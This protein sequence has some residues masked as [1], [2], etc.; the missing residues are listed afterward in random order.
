MKRD[1]KDVHIYFP[2]KVL[3]QLKRLAGRNRRSVSAE[4]VIAV[5]EKLTR[6]DKERTR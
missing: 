6:D 3:N 4:I 1:T 2:L 5:E